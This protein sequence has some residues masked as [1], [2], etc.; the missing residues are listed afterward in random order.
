MRGTFQLGPEIGDILGLFV[1]SHAER[2]GWLTRKQL[3]SPLFLRI[4]QPPSTHPNSRS[5]I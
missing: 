4:L 5:G 2:E 1:G 3:R